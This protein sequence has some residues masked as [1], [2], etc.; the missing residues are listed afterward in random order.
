MPIWIWEFVR[1]SREVAFG[2]EVVAPEREGHALPNPLLVGER[3]RQQAVGAAFRTQA[4]VERPCAELGF[5]GFHVD[6]APGGI[7]LC[8]VERVVHLAVGERDVAAV[9]QHVASQ[10]D[11]SVLTI[12]HS[13]A[14]DSERAELAAKAA[15]RDRLDATDA[16]V[17][18]ERYTHH[19]TQH[20]AELCVAQLLHLLR[21]G[22]LG[23]RLGFERFWAAVGLY[24]SDYRQG[25]SSPRSVLRGDS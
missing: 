10:V 7:G 11:L 5:V 4:Q 13:H 9:S 3:R 19:A 18:L 12:G 24:Y 6:D 1:R 17:V 16:T 23:G 21:W 8:G 22:H 2:L 14:I 20:V 15:G 25:D